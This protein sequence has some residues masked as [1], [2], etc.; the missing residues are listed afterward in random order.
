MMPDSFLRP[1]WWWPREGDT[2][3][4]RCPG[5]GG[6]AERNTKRARWPFR[7]CWWL[8]VGHIGKDTRAPHPLKAGVTLRSSH[9]SPESLAPSL[10]PS[11]PVPHCPL[12][13]LHSVLGP[14]LFLDHHELFPTAGIHAGWSLRPSL[15]PPAFRSWLHEGH[16]DNPNKSHSLVR[17]PRNTPA[18]P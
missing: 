11:G 16:S 3:C 13:S 1:G 7:C 6:W 8:P 18:L 9:S 12:H 4:P 10:Y 5:K 15:L 17:F 14:F 2:R